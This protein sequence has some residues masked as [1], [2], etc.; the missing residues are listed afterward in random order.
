MKKSCP[1][2]NK[3][4]PFQKQGIL[5]T[6]LRITYWQYTNADTLGYTA[7]KKGY[8]K[9][10]ANADNPERAIEELSKVALDYDDEHLS[11]EQ[12][13]DFKNIQLSKKQK[14]S[15]GRLIKA[16]IIKSSK[17]NSRDL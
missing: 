5:M 6:I 7:V 10:I 13:Q 11:D 8:D 4:F 12:R 1:D 3:E 16:K 2:N 17:K 14:K 9:V 15:L